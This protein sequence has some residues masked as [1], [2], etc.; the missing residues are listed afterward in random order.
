M[1]ARRWL[2][3]YMAVAVGL[4]SG[5]A[6]DREV[7][8]RRTGCSIQRSARSFGEITRS[9]HGTLGFWALCRRCSRDGYALRPIRPSWA[10]CVRKLASPL[11]AAPVRQGHRRWKV[12]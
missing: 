10:S 4:C 8:E 2:R 7:W 3:K 1:G 12:R 5:P 11:R 6:D 9:C